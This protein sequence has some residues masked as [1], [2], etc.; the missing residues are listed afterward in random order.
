[1]GEVGKGRDVTGQEGPYRAGFWLDSYKCG[2]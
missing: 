2:D 1:M